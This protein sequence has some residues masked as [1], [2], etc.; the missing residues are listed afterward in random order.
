[1]GARILGLRMAAREAIELAA[2]HRGDADAPLVD[3]QRLHQHQVV[4]AVGQEAGK[5][6]DPALGRGPRQ[7]SW[8][9]ARRRDRVDPSFGPEEL[10][11]H[12]RAGAAPAA[13][14]GS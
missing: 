11:E 7:R 3:R 6:A 8:D 12:Y 9:A 4:T 2:V 1:T 5:R 10:H 14:A 13:R